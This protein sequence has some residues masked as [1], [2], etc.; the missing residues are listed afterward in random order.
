MAKNGMKEKNNLTPVMQQYIDLSLKYNDCIVFYRLGDFYEVFFDK[1]IIMAKELNITLTKRGK[2][3]GKYIPMC[4]I[5]HH[6]SSYYIARLIKAGHKIAICEQMETPEEAKK[7]RGYKA[8]IRREITRII[9]PATVIEEDLLN[10]V[11]NNYLM[12]IVDN[13]SHLSIAWCD[14]TTNVFF[15][16]K[17][18]LES[19]IAEISRI[20]PKEIILSNSLN[21]IQEI[22]SFIKD[23]NIFLNVYAD[24]FFNFNRAVRHITD[25]YSVNNVHN[26]FED[27]SESNIMACGMIIEYIKNTHK[28][29]LPRIFAPKLFSRNSFMILDDITKRGLELEKCYDGKIKNS[30]FNTIDHTTTA[31]GKRLLQYYLNYP[32][33]NVDTINERL[34]IVQFFISQNDISNDITN[35][36]KVISDI[37]RSISRVNAQKCIPKDLHTIKNAI[38]IF[39]EIKSILSSNQ[40]NLLISKIVQSINISDDLYTL[41]NSALS[42]DMNSQL[43]DGN[44][45]ANGF[46]GELDGLRD[47]NNSS[48]IEIDQLLEKYISELY[49][50]SLKIKHNNIIGY[51]I[52]TSI[53]HKDK[54]ESYDKFI[55]KQTLS[56]CIR[57]TTLE[58]QTIESKINN[59]Q[60]SALSIEQ[61]LFN[62][63]CHS[64]TEV[65]SDLYGTTHVISKL[66]VLISMAYLSKE[67]KYVRPIIHND[68]SL[69]IIN[70]RHP[71][72]EIKSDFVK[73]D[74]CLSESFINLITGPNMSGK[75]TFLRQNAIIVIM[76]QMGMFIPADSADIGIVDRIFS[77]IGAS[78]NIAKGQSTF[79]VEMIEIANMLNNATEKS[80]MII[81]EIGRGTAIKDGIAIALAVIEYIH[82]VIGSRAIIATHFHEIVKLNNELSHIKCLKIKIKQWDDKILFLHKVEEGISKESFGINVAKISGVPQDVVCRARV[83]IDT[84]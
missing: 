39:K 48:S 64:V 42:D 21:D 2:Y 53:S 23:N 43:K 6:S 63:L 47:I 71:V 62:E 61:G 20:N 10:D 76:A 18:N 30:L 41:L 16:T 12:I 70:G 75:S 55:H 65:S 80:L 31:G 45:I 50:T 29:E 49:I 19:I 8:I 56:N 3:D 25:Y 27:D 34:D 13:K 60:S 78:D 51:F 66:D 11:L 52:E 69:N 33:N 58:L 68:K 59:A 73:N 54:I 84:E 79:M 28:S 57:Y 82:N 5:P 46:S 38:A 35:L 26:F 40:Q 24:S 81:D 17:L 4:G 44:V 22:N 36:L 32:L 15:Y 14:I 9:T 1:A 37:E 83:L 67:K 77:R 74:C 72:I 7:Q